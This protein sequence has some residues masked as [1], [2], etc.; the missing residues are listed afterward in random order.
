M[1]AVDRGKTRSFAAD[2][3]KNESYDGMEEKIIEMVHKRGLQSTIVYSAFYA[4]SLEKLKRLD[5]YIVRAW[6]SG[7]LYPEKSTGTKLD[8]TLL[9]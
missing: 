4:K 2:K 9:K 8:F 5:G 6:M 3:D 1:K 7:H